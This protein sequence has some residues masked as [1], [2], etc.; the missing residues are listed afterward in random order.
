MSDDARLSEELLSAYVDGEVTDAERAAVEARLARDETWQH[1][2]ADIVAARDA[3]SGLPEREAPSGFWLRVLTN[4]AE[5]ASIPTSNSAIGRHCSNKPMTGPISI[6]P[7]AAMNEMTTLGIPGSS[8]RVIMSRATPTKAVATPSSA[9]ALKALGVGLMIRIV[10]Q[11]PTTIASQRRQPT[12][13][14]KKITAAAVMIS[15]ETRLIAES[16]ASGM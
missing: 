1:L 11:K 3:V 7:S 12:S 8:L 6:E 9:H 2:H 10:P 14:A 15:G 16:S 4:V 13:S 5:I